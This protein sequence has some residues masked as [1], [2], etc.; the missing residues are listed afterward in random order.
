M[1]AD[2]DLPRELGTQAATSHTPRSRLGGRQ[3]LVGRHAA[4][5]R[6]R[7]KPHPPAQRR[8]RSK[9]SRRCGGGRRA[10][11]GALRRSEQSAA[12]QSR[13]CS[14]ATQAAPLAAAARLAPEEQRP[15]VPRRR[16]SGPRRGAGRR[17]DVGEGV[18]APHRLQGAR[19]A[20][21]A[22]VLHEVGRRDAPVPPG[23]LEPVLRGADYA[24]G[25]GGARALQVAVHVALGHGGGSPGRGG[26][27]GG[28]LGRGGRRGRG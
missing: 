10:C 22:Q 3:H 15:E 8:R 25:A 21:R 11:T 19:V 1:M 13:L 28:G 18:R 23:P 12:P 17:A 24:L 27:R 2:S 7:A 16:G 14:S 9:C 26:R 5:K 6:R 4:R 20:R